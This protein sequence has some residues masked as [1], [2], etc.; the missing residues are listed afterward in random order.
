[1]SA[2]LATLQIV[3][4]IVYLLMGGDFLVR[5][6]M[7]LAR[8]ARIS[9]MVVGLTVVAFGTSAPELVVT[10]QAVIGGYPDIAIGNVVG[11]NIANVFL[12]M[13]IPALIY[14]LACNQPS[15]RNDA[16]FMLA[17]S[18][19]FF[20]L[21]ADG[22]LT[23]GDGFLL[24]AG[25]VL[26]L[27]MQARSEW[28]SD[29]DI[30]FQSD[31]PIVLGLP[32]KKRMI[33]ILIFFGIVMLPLG[34]N[35]LIDGATGMGER[36]GIPDQVIGLTVIALSTSAPELATTLVAAVKRQADVAVGNV[37]GSNIL[38]IL[39]IMGA[40]SLASLRELT[41]PEHVMAVDIPLMLVGA[42][43]LT[44]VTFRRMS[45]GQRLGGAMLGIYVTYF[46]LLLSGRA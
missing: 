4:G 38:N 37:I 30:P 11:S 10:L 35:L 18:G 29:M 31:L 17:V 43:I 2:S 23:R 16:L 32:S 45:I 19:L 34:A 26:F 27:A 44:V 40:A 25:L 12:V 8:T 13:S 7:G 1:M 20:V 22:Q 3:G 39:G 21:C 14:P 24:L 15:A 9:P 28:I 41:V 42:L 6:A 33:A 46:F 36:L 5:G